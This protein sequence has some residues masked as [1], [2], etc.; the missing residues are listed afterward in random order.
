[1]S[2][3]MNQEPTNEQQGLNQPGQNI[4]KKQYQAPKVTPHGGL[5]ELVQA[6]PHVGHDAGGFADCSLS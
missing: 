1:M 4:V 5:A 3:S 6:N 2:I